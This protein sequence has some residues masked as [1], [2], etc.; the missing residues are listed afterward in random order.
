[1][2]VLLTGQ[3]VDKVGVQAVLTEPMAAVHLVQRV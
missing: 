3:L 2:G 1:M